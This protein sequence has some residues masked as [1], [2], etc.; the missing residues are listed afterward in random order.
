MAVARKQKTD[1]EQSSSN[2][3][4]SRP[5]FITLTPSD[6]PRGAGASEQKNSARASQGPTTG[7]P[8]T[9]NDPLG[10]RFD[11]DLTL[12]VKYETI[13]I[14][15]DNVR[16]RTYNGKPIGPVLLVKSGDVLY[17]T[18]INRLLPLDPETHVDNGHHAW[19]TT[20][21]H[22]HGLHVAPQGPLGHTDEESDNGY[23]WNSKPSDPFD[24]NV[25]VQK[26]KI[27]IPPKPCCGYLLV[28][29]AQ[30]WISSGAGFQRSGGCADHRT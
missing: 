29:C 1:P 28:P 3:A 22:F 11:L 6:V 23:S 24:P 30:A 5:T 8:A 10:K 15:K 4:D 2:E 21:I 20:N 7:Q 13:Q 14:G 18:L 26:Y 27:K 9:R 16:L 17:L 19:N 12:E 25:S